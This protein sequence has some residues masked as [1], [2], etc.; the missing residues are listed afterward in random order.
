MKHRGRRSR[1]SNTTDEALRGKNRELQKEIRHLKQRIRQLER[2]LGMS[3]SHEEAGVE[4]INI[5][6]THDKQCEN[7][8]K[9]KMK[10]AIVWSPSGEI[11]WLVCQICKHREK[12]K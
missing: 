9:D 4:E 10:E 3:S 12:R 1:G 8:G 7:C 11:A 6:T 5:P 2:Q